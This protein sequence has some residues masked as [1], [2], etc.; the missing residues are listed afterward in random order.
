MAHT[1]LF[2]VRVVRG[3]DRLSATA[4]RIDEEVAGHF[5]QPQQLLDFLLGTA[6]REEDAGGPPTP[7]PAARARPDG[8]LPSPNGDLSCND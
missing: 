4:R 3:A 7:A 1:H 8:G 6:R 2:I 5:T